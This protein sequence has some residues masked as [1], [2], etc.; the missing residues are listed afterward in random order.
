M[1]PPFYA[2]K[3]FKIGTSAVKYSF[4]SVK[5]Y[6]LLARKT[7]LGIAKSLAGKPPKSHYAHT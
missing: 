7:K 6:T 2:R 1:L 4:T 3:G 5:N